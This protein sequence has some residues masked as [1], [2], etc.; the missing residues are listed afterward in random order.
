MSNYSD[1]RKPINIQ[2]RQEQTESLYADI[3]EVQQSDT[4]DISSE[5]QIQ[6]L[7]DELKSERARSVA[8]LQKLKNAIDVLVDVLMA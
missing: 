3:E 5:G 8:L 1:K 2:S 7:R 6:W 4:M